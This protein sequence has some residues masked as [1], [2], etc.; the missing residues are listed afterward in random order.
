MWQALI[1]LVGICIALASRADVLST[2]DLL[3]VGGCG[4][5]LPAARPLHRDSRL[6][7]AARAWADGSALARALDRGGY[8]ALTRGGLRVSGRD[9]AVLQS[10]RRSRCGIISDPRFRDVGAYQRGAD[11]WL[12]LAAP[13]VVPPASQAPLLVT[14]AVELINAAR[15][16]GATCGSRSYAPVPPVT[17]SS[18]LG[19][20]AR[21]HAADMAAHNYFEHQDLSGRSPADRVRASGYPEKL[22]GENIAYGPTTVEEVVRGWLDSPGHCENIMDPRFREMGLAYAQGRRERHG[23]YWVQLLVE[24]KA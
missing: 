5:I 7:A 17:L 23:L 19:D 14:R 18:T 22:V 3:R 10:L 1:I 6:D 11:S 4:G 8:P 16:R 24:P 21:G 13:D 2:V 20:V 9:S 15:A 12:V